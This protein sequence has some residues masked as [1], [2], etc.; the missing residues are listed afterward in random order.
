MGLPLFNALV[1]GQFQEYRQELYILKTADFEIHFWSHGSSIRHFDAVGSE[2]Y[3]F[4]EKPPKNSHN[5][6]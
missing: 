4:G 2:T 5:G 3:L 1:W 6:P